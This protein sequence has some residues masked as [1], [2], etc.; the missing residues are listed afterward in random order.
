MLRVGGTGRGP[1]RARPDSRLRGNDVGMCGLGARAAAQA[2]RVQIP[3][4]AGMTWVCAGMTMVYVRVCT[5][6]T[7]RV[8]E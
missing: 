3:A 8:A 4:F 5:G 6:M 1:G 2:A 7:R